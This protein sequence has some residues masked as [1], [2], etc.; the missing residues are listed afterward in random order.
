LSLVQAL[1]CSV[2]EEKKTKLCGTKQIN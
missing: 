1:I 2:H